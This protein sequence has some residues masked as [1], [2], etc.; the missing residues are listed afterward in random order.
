MKHILVL[1]TLS[2]VTSVY[3]VTEKKQNKK[4]QDK[5]YVVPAPKAEILIRHDVPIQTKSEEDRP[6]NLFYVGITRGSLTYRLS[7]LISSNVDFSPASIGISLG[8][9][10][11][12]EL[13]FYKGYFELNGEW[14]SFK[15]ESG[16]FSQKLNIYQASFIQNVDLAWSIKKALF[17]SGGIGLTPVYLTAEQSIFSNSVS[18]L[19]GMAL[20]KFN[21]IFPI[22]KKY[23]YDLGLKTCWGSVGGMEI[24]ISTLSLGIN[25]E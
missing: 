4:N 20:L 12:N 22:K 7:S 9:K 8:K 3:A 13:H 2:F 5:V 10:V 14:Q 19:G 23:E 11:A 16:V 18:S 15:R 17:F 24:F 21:V 25:F 6:Q 1:C